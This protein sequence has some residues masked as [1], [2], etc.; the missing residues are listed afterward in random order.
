[1]RP[2]KFGPQL[3]ISPN[4]LDSTRNAQVVLKRM[5]H[6]CRSNIKVPSIYKEVH[7]LGGTGIGQPTMGPAGGFVTG[8]GGLDS[9][10]LMA[11]PIDEPAMS[12]NPCKFHFI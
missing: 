1:M 12:T 9:S 11:T 4:I 10:G 5:P 8:N 2:S 3:G 6:A 7:D